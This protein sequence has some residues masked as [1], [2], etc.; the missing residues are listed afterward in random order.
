[1]PK[2]SSA[3]SWVR[4]SRLRNLGY[5]PSVLGE[6]EVVEESGEPEVTRGEAV[7]ARGLGEGTREISLA[8]AGGSGDE[9]DL[10]L[11]DPFAAGEPKHDG[12]VEASG[13]SEVDVLDGSIEPELGELQKPPEP[14]VLA[15]RG[16]AV[17]EHG[18]PVL[19]G[20]GLHVGHTE[21]LGKGLGPAPESEFMEPVERGFGKHVH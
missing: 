1:M 19:E 13:G 11:S 12:L 3:T 9:R 2:S 18:E 7:A 6:G 21:L 10:M 4:S 16:L 5:D 8:G 14:T 17:E 15:F 20:E